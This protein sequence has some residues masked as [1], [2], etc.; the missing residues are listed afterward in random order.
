[1]AV[2]RNA[3]WS[4]QL[5][6]A[7]GAAVPVPVPS[8]TI[9]ISVS[10]VAIPTVPVAIPVVAVTVV[11]VTATIPVVA[12][13]CANGVRGLGIR[14]LG[15]RS[16]RRRR[17]CGDGGLG[18]DDDS[19]LAGRS[20]ARRRRRWC[21]DRGTAFRGGTGRI[22]PTLRAGRERDEC[23]RHREQPHDARQDQCP[24]WSSS[25]LADGLADGL[26]E[27][28]RCPLAGVDDGCRCCR[29]PVTVRGPSI[30]G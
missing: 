23:S 12:V 15:I 19:G 26:G 4:A 1:M 7:S 11:A 27:G 6:I 22:G 29:I 5:T 3:V 28:G 16:A 25:G 13:I 10:A 30:P 20:G 17:G 8:T 21:T 18:G 24:D 2:A 14:G 9:A